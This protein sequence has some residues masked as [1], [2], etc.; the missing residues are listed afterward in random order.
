MRY[1]L[2]TLLIVLAVGPAL[3]AGGWWIVRDEVRRFALGEAFAEVAG[4]TLVT[5]AGLAC[6]LGF[7]FLLAY[8]SA[9]AADAMTGKR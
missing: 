1:R 6:V 8:V 7:I 4:A 5:L 3:I 9:S 2:R